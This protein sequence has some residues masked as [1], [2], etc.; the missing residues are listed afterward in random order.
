MPLHLSNQLQSMRESNKSS[1]AILRC[2]IDGLIPDIEVFANSNA[3]ILLGGDLE[4]NTRNEKVN[5]EYL[6]HLK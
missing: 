3:K 1:S 4:I 5:D 6:N 2:L